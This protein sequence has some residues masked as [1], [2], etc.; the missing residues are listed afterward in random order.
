MIG[1]FYLKY[2]YNNIA[3]GYLQPLSVEPKTFAIIATYHK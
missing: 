3:N 2:V 1:N